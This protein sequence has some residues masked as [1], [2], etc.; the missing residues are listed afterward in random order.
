[1]NILKFVVE[2]SVVW[3]PFAM[4]MFIIHLHYKNKQ[5]T[6][7]GETKK[8]IAYHHW[9]ADRLAEVDKEEVSRI[10][11]GDK[12]KITNYLEN[13]FSYDNYLKLEKI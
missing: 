6:N 8:L 4:L 9:L 5:P 10:N 12:E 13:L 7:R 2:T 1:M 3:L 11:N